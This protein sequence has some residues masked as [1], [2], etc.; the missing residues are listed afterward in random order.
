MLLPS[1]LRALDQREEVTVAVTSV[2]VDGAV[3]AADESC[4]ALRRKS[5]DGGAGEA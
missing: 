3:A 4:G 2:D 5:D 1:P